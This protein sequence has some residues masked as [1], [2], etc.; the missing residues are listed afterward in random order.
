M[1][2]QRAIEKAQEQVKTLERR[3][4]EL[5]A[6]AAELEAQVAAAPSIIERVKVRRDARDL[7]GEIG[8]A[9]GEL[10]RARAA[11]ATAEKAHA[12]AFKQVEKL[13]KVEARQMGAV[14]ALVNDL[15][16][17]LGELGETRQ[18]LAGYAAM[19]K[20]NPM[21]LPQYLAGLKVRWR[22]AGAMQ[23]EGSLFRSQGNGRAA[24]ARQEAQA[25]EAE[26]ERRAMAQQVAAREARRSGDNSPANVQ[27]ILAKL[28]FGDGAG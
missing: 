3:R 22:M 23:G 8:E 18:Q 26:A 19:R 12:A 24:K 13:W 17:A 28:G 20:S 6:A 16:A 10:E 5:E 11:V 7:R 4:A 25:Q 27:T 2:T 9:D 15:E 21:D 14:V 1:F